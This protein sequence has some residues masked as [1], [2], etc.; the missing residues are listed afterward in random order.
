MAFQ[1]SREGQLTEE[2]LNWGFWWVTHKVQVRRWFTVVL[3]I[4]AF[5][6]VAYAGYG[7]ADW[8]FGSGVLERASFAAYERPAIDL[9]LFRRDTPQRP[10]IEPAYIL[11]SSEDSFDLV[12]QVTNPSKSFWLEFD[13]RFESGGSTVGTVQHGFLLPASKKYLYVLGVKGNRPGS[14]TLQLNNVSVHRVDPHVI[15]PDY[16]TWARARLNF[17]IGDI[18][19]KPPAPTDPLPVSRATFTVKNDTGFSYWKAG[20]FVLL[21]TGTS[22]SGANYVVIT[23]LRAGETRTVDASWFADMPGVSDVQVTPDLNIFDNSIYI[24]PGR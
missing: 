8:Y 23:E 4:V 7:F 20:F 3:G 2:K 14:V 21:R 24:P 12:S 19:F 17:K 13:Y 9:S 15:K 16:L 22:V 18:Q 6:L 1:V 10:V 11:A 5:V